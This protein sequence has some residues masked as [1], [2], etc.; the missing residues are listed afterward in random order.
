MDWM[1]IKEDALTPMPRARAS[2]ATAGVRRRLSGTGAGVFGYGL[3][4]AK[5]LPGGVIGVVA[6]APEVL[7]GLFDFGHRKFKAKF[8]EMEGLVIV[9]GSH[10]ADSGAVEALATQ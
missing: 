3:E 2:T 6:H 10:A 7:H 1:E 5:L 8:F 9:A 4:V